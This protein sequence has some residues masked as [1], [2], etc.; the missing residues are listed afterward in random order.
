MKYRIKRI[1]SCY[2]FY[3]VHHGFGVMTRPFK[4]TGKD[5]LTWYNVFSRV[6]N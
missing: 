2:M 5:P 6:Y 3:Y 1:R 4:A